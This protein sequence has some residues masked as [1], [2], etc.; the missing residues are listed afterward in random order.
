MIAAVRADDLIHAGVA[1]FETAIHDADRLAP[2]ERRPAMAR[3]TGKRDC[4]A[5]KLAAQPR[6]TAIV[7][8]RGWDGG[9][10]DSKSGTGHG[11]RTVHSTHRQAVVPAL[12][13]SGAACPL[14]PDH[15]TR[16]LRTTYL[17][18]LDSA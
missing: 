4:H 8:A 6:V 5:V 18:E 12:P 11:V 7:R 16:V 15:N 9:R 17:T 3:L 14:S 1:A 10:T 13:G 2:N